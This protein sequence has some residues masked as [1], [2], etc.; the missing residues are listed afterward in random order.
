[1][2]VIQGTSGDDT[3]VVT[4]EG[5][6]IIEQQT[7][8]ASS[9]AIRRVSES[10]A[11]EQANGLSEQASVSADGR[12]VVFQS[13]ATN[14]VSG[15]T[16]NQQDIFVKDLQ[17]G[18]VR[19][20]STD[21]TGTQGDNRSQNASI[22]AEGRY[23]VFESQ[24]GNWAAGDLRGTMDIFLKDLQTGTLTRISQGTGTEE[25]AISG[26]ASFSSDGSKIVFASQRTNLVSNDANGGTADIFVYTVATGQLQL[27]STSATGQAANST[28]ETPVFS[29]DGQSVAFVSYASNLIAND[30]RNNQAD[31]LIKDL[32]TGAVRR[33]SETVDGVG[34]DSGSINAI[35]FAPDGQSIMFQSGASNLVEGDTNNA[36][37][38]FIKNLQTNVVTRISVAADGS[39][40]QNFA[41]FDGSFVGSANLAVFESQAGSLVEG[42]QNNFTD[43][44]VKDIQTGALGIISRNEAGQAS[45]GVSRAAQAS[46][47]GQFVVF[48]SNASNLVANDTN[49]VSDIFI[50]TLSISSQDLGGNDRVQSFVDF[51]LP[52]G[53]ESLEL[54]G[55]AS[56]LGT[57][58]AA[59]NQ[60]AGNVADNW[61]YGGSGDD[62]LL[63]KAGDD[64]LEGG[65]GQDRLR[66]GFGNDV[67][68]GGADWDVLWGGAGNDR[69]EG[70]GDSS[71]AYL[72]R[73]GDAQDRILDESVGDQ[74][75]RDRL[76]FG[77]D[78]AANQL[79]L[80]RVGDDLQL[81]VIGT[82]D[83]VTIENWYLDSR[84]QIERIID[85]QGQRL[86][87][88][89]VDQ[90]VQAMAALTPP[91]LGQ[92]NLS[93]SVQTQLTAALDL[94]WN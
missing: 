35:A 10:A 80:S 40:A 92:T 14:L 15:D 39:Q 77:A 66:G 12:F 13:R 46:A 54:M 85:G 94:A 72:F 6:N 11:G 8:I 27:V 18:E 42:D 36:N 83:Q 55:S 32:N 37:D 21:T 75:L 62:G 57:G 78:I 48:H 20:V 7:T 31:V 84:Y 56:L 93:D 2:S 91:V 9:G 64:N 52:D 89:Q 29:P 38:I 76:S 23:V 24:A 61:L 25:F 50:K 33:A 60:L 79:W 90:L 71:D 47:D 28:N 44:Y 82:N 67:L 22:S 81:Q 86:Q 30:I 58:N 70:G 43:V 53:V 49:V 59:N 65:A 51:V 45:N 34:G 4:E 87:L 68:Y 63:G 3:Y 88:A 69:M 41:S 5:T 19:L 73:R 17:T 26:S 1:M 16:N 74:S